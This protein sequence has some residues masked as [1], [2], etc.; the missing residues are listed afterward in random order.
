MA[1]MYES[2][3]ARVWHYYSKMSYY[4]H[5]RDFED[6]DSFTD[7]AISYARRL[8][9]DQVLIHYLGFR[10]YK[11]VLYRDFAKAGEYLNNAKD[12]I[13]KHKFVIP[14]FTCIYR[15][16]NAM[17]SVRSLEEATNSKDR[18]RTSE[19]TR[20]A[21]R[22]IKLAIRASDKMAMYNCECLMFQGCFYW[23]L[24]DQKVALEWWQEA[25][26]KADRLGAKPDWAR[27]YM[28]IG[29]RLSEDRSKYKELNGITAEKYLEMARTMF[30]QLDLKWDL[31]EV[32]RVVSYL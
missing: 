23:L 10:A 14:M 3:I 1:E 4:Y 2:S 9:L 27:I 5:S 11:E 6:I 19:Y 30:E 31:D 12:L 29:K 25:L 17:L 32:D 13:Q 18:S 28:E 26:H 20:K 15:T 7:E 21:R 16:A 8:G 22:D 24:D